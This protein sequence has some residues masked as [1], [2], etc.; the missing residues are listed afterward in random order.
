MAGP[1]ED[2]ERAARERQYAD[3]KKELRRGW[4]DSS[5]GDTDKSNNK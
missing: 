1:Q 4:G 5:D 3:L 2:N